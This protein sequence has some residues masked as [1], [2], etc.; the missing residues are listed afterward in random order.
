MKAAIKRLNKKWAEK[1]EYN[2][3]LFPNIVKADITLLG[4]SDLWQVPFLCPLHYVQNNKNMEG[5]SLKKIK[6][7]KSKENYLLMFV[8]FTGKG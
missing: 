5:S 8:C 3:A 2:I 4:S 6:S 1:Y 7:W